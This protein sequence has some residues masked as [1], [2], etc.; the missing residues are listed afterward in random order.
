MFPPNNYYLPD[1]K[2]TESRRADNPIVFA[3]D[4]FVSVT[5][6][7]R[8]DIIPRNCRFLQGAYTDRHATKRLRTSIENCE[9]TVELLLNYRK[10]GDPFWNLLY[11]SPLVDGNGDVRFFLGGQ[12]NCS[13]TIH[14]RTDVLRILSLNDEDTESVIEGSRKAPSVRS[15]ESNSYSSYGKSSFF[16]SFKKYNANTIKVRDEAGME[17]ELIDRIGKL[18]FKTQVEEFYTAYS[19]VYFQI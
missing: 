11:V 8:T 6:Y 15:T 4:G 3:S 7:S 17:G 19:K 2:L 14:S 5:G 10:N 16:K 9:E 13:T 1:L 18:Q 12:I